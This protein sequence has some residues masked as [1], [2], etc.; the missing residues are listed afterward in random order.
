MAIVVRFAPSPTGP[1]HLGSA[2]TALFNYLFAR[3]NRGKFILRI[4]DT[5]RERSRPE[6]EKDIL[7]IL[8]W[9]G[10]NYDEFYRQSE[11]RELYAQELEKLLAADRAYWSDEPVEEDLP[12]TRRPARQ[13]QTG[14][15]SRVIRFKNPQT[16]IEFG[17][18]VRGKVSFTTAAL[19]DFVIAKSLTEPLYHFASVVDDVVSGVTDVIRGE[20][21]LSN[22]PRQI[23]LLE[24]LN[25][26]RPVYAHI[27]LILAPDRSKLSKRHG[28]VS[29]TEYRRQGYLPEALTNFL[30]TL[31]WSPQVKRLTQELFSSEELVK[32][33]DLGEVQRGGA[34]FNIEKLNWFNREYLKRLSP[35]KLWSV[36]KTFLPRTNDK[37]EKLL[38]EIIGRI[39]KLGELAELARAG[40]FDY[41]FEPPAVDKKMLRE[42]KYLPEI[43][44]R[45]A[46]V[47]AGE[48]VKEKIKETL[49]NYATQIGR[50]K[51]LWSLRVALTGRERSPDPFTVAAV[52]GKKETIDR[53]VYAQKV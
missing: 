2:R 48:F 33:F 13:S 19:G 49:W 5:D 22:T 51:V 1:L 42:T 29:V 4:D 52:L 41:L 25:G 15:R 18:V 26:T 20:D 14:R 17:D 37:L 21:H 44:K 40:E 6:F 32:Y 7:E 31:G 3:Q 38:P 28:A 23:L 47:P 53:L 24:A 27:P 35:D 43:Q 12:A 50:D 10:L 36:A 46:Q 16:E 34:I 39:N 9:L 45:L 8:S 30:A 11:R